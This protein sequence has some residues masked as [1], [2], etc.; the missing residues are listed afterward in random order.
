MH[1]THTYAHTHVQQQRARR[2]AVATS[3]AVKCT[4]SPLARTRSGAEPP[5]QRPLPANAPLG[6]S[7]VALG[8]RWRARERVSASLASSL[9]F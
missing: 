2:S 4:L 9:R 7:A 6:G 5:P 1:K 3:S 8:E